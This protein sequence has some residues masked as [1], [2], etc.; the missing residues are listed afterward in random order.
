MSRHRNILIVS[1]ALVIIG[2]GISFYQSQN[3]ANDI[4][5]QQQSL[6]S[7]A[8]MSLIK[9]LDPEKSKD[10]VYSVQISDFNDGFNVKADLVDPS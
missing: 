6:S 4:T 7:G 10:G 9:N 3:E 5:T 8:S 1:A 2:I